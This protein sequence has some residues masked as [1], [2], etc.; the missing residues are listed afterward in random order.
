MGVCASRRTPSLD[1][2]Y[3][4]D[5]PEVVVLGEGSCS[6]VFRA[7][8]RATGALVAVK[9][10][11]KAQQRLADADP[12]Q[13]EREVALL[14]RCASHPNVIAL[15]D[16]MET[17]DFVYI[18]T[19]LA[20]GGELFQALIDEGAY[21]EWDARRFV[22]G[23]LEA[24][25]FLHELGIAHRDVKPENLL[26][27]SASPKLANIK[28]ADFG[29]AALVE[30]ST[31]LTN[32]RLTWAYCA[33]EVFQAS[34]TAK[35]AVD[36]EATTLPLPARAS[37]VGVQ[38]DMWSVGIV[39]Y[40][41]LSGTHPFDSDGRQTRSQMVSNI[42]SGQFA[43]AG[44]CWD[45]VSNEVK[46]LISALLSVAPEQR[47]TAAEALAHEW[48]TSPRTPRETLAV[49]Q[50]ETEGLEQYRRTMRRKFRV[51]LLSFPVLATVAA[52]T[53]RRS[54]KKSRQSTEAATCAENEAF[55]G[56]PLPVAGSADVCPS[57]LESPADSP[58]SAASSCPSSATSTSAAVV[59]TAG[60]DGADLRRTT[61]Q[62]QRSVLSRVFQRAPHEEKGGAEVIEHE[63]IQAKATPTAAVDDEDVTVE[64]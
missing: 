47:P 14:R 57:S 7:R 1:E 32:E 21:S 54:L 44:P 16:V 4:M 13:W 11:D 37:G 30:E 48:F 29:L 12:V 26:L 23:L 36:P 43:M 6:R 15:H 20:E 8:S 28:L 2:F 25:R 31:L 46:A 56:E 50:S 39:L 58:S 40:V 45:A 52:D 60:E 27:T 9:R 5:A 22:A 59:A 24:L 3:E 62:K 49:S 18:I 63:P 34:V 42:Q 64:V 10:L 41:L 38:S 51:R 33:P 53:L 55:E 35:P 61:M 17:P 19:E